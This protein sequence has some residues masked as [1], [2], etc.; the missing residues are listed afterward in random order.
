M[1][2]TD[3]RGVFSSWSDRFVTYPYTV[4]SST[5]GSLSAASECSERIGMDRAMMTINA[6]R[7]SALPFRDMIPESGTVLIIS[8]GGS[9]EDA[10]SA[11]GRRSA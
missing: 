6:I 2:T 8:G 1:T 10:L 4:L 3:S 9:S 11:D 5:T 7:A